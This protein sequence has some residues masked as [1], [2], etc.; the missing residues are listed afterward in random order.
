MIYT[1]SGDEL[2]TSENAMITSVEPA[3]ENVIKQKIMQYL[4]AKTQPRLQ[5]D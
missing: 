1:I 3:I 4:T 5:K 2:L